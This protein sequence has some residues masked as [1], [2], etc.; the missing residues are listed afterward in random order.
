[1]TD[2]KINAKYFRKVASG[3]WLIYDSLP[4]GRDK[5]AAYR[6]ASKLSYR[7]WKAE[8]RAKK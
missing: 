1:M 5:N 3:A 7:A 2:D 8:Q 6:T 4:E